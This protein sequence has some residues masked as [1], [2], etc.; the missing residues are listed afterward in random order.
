MANLLEDPN[1]IASA[2]ND[3][4]VPP[5]APSPAWV[6][7]GFDFYTANDSTGYCPNLVAQVGGELTGMVYKLGH[8]DGDTFNI[9]FFTEVA[10]GEFY[11]QSISDEYFF[12]YSDSGY[13][14]VAINLTVASGDIVV[15]ANSF[16]FSAGSTYFDWSFLS[17]YLP[18]SAR[19]AA[20]G[21]PP[22]GEFWTDFRGT[23]E[24]N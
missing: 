8:Q 12:E 24:T 23:A 11:C 18:L 14:P 16:D 22:P 9:V 3:S 15:L 19:I 6:D 17:K 7:G 20:G 5:T 21:P 2:T 13:D 10:P 4:G 1:L